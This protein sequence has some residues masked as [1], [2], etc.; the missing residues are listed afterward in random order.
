[1]VHAVA[2]NVSRLIMPF[3]PGSSLA[4]LGVQ[5]A[6]IDAALKDVVTRIEI[7]RITAA[8]AAEQE[9]AQ[10]E[11]PAAQSSEQSDRDDPDRIV[12]LSEASRLSSLSIDTLRRR[13][14]DKWVQLSERRF[15]M[16]RRD[17]L[18]LSG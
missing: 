18:T 8:K 13:H 10:A 4:L 9:V 1:M 2:C 17:A 7:L 12:S 5:L 6:C 3:V 11:Q 14:R 15:G 16:R